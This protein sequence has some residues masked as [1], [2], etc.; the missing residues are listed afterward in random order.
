M[1]P[2]LQ[3]IC[4]GTH[5]GRNERYCKYIYICAMTLFISLSICHQ[6]N[7]FQQMEK[8]NSKKRVNSLKV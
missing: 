2:S 1:R 4:M 7:A 8:H 3:F 5:L 6:P